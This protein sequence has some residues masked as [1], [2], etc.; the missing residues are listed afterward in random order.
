MK[1]LR[2]KE[3]HTKKEREIVIDKIKELNTYLY[4]KDNVQLTCIILT[5]GTDIDTLE[6][7]ESLKNRLSK[8]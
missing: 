6:S 2:I 5:D 8:L 3:Y 7:I 4:Q 1:F